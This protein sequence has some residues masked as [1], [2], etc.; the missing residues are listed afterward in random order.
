VRTREDDKG[1]IR[2]DTAVKV[3]GPG[4]QAAAALPGARA[5]LDVAG[6]ERAQSASLTRDL[7][8]SARAP[9]TGGE[10]AG[11][12]SAEQRAAL[13]VAA[14]ELAAYGPFATRVWKAKSV[15]GLSF[16]V[17]LE[18]WDLPVGAPPLLEISARVDERDLDVARTLLE[19][20]LAHHGV[21]LAP[22]EQQGNKT[23]RALQ[24]ARD[25]PP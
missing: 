19:R 6:A 10:L 13:P 9:R 11:A 5:E 23:R 24:A 2:L 4:A 1:D 25:A 14:E 17:T 20:L 16:P 3:R 8:R 7:P 12:L 18:V 15:A 21:A 22:P